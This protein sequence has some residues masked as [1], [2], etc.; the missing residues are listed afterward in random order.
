M[1]MYLCIYL[2]EYYVSYFWYCGTWPPRGIFISL[3]F[4]HWVLSQHCADCQCPQQDS[5]RTPIPCP[6]RFLTPIINRINTASLPQTNCTTRRGIR[7]GPRIM[8][9]LG[10]DLAV[11]QCGGCK[12]ATSPALLVCRF[13]A[14]Q[15]GVVRA[16]PKWNGTKPHGRPPQSKPAK[17]KANG[18]KHWLIRLHIGALIV[19]Q[20]GALVDVSKGLF[21]RH[22]PMV[23]GICSGRGV[24][25]TD[26]GPS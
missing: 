18:D 1:Y 15:K 10:S 25:E 21:T 2:F 6:L 4:F 11:F 23:L 22:P 13:L 12:I 5:Y 7:P 24:A 26:P 16:Q 17:V 8:I 19:N 3:I 9:F 14:S 20:N